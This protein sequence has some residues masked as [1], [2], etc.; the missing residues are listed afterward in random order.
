METWDLSILKTFHDKGKI[1]GYLVGVSNGDTA[2][3]TRKEYKE[4]LK[5][6]K[7]NENRSHSISS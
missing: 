1:E 4:F 7:E 2:Y 6:R 3:L 5:V